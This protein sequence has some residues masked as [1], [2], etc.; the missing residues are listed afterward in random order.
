MRQVVTPILPKKKKVKPRRMV[1]K[2][3]RDRAGLRRLLWLSAAAC[4]MGC[5]T[6]SIWFVVSG[7]W[8]AMVDKVD[9]EIVTASTKMGFTLQNVYLEGQHHTHSKDILKAL[10]VQIGQPIF[11]LSLD[12]MRQRLE[13]INW[14]KYAVVE[15]QLP[16]T[17][18]VHI[19]ERQAVAMW[20]NAGQLYLIDSQGNTIV[21]DDM[22]PF[23]SMMIMVGDDAPLYTNSLL[24]MLHQDPSLA[25]HVASAIR[26]GE[27]RWN[28]RFYNGLEVKLPEENKEDAW[29]FFV[30]LERNKELLEKNVKHVDLRVPGK[31]YIQMGSDKK[32]AT[33]QDK[34]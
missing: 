15:R 8:G 32:N 28:V 23:K 26:V 20:Q 30:Q 19:I 6:V 25:K 4:V 5:I 13:K 16:H 34:R 33:T 22:K 29:T 2:S 10:D 21:E 27:R 3:R 9:N 17:L 14:V 24:E 12:E 11:S 1:V 18:H 7:R 31:V